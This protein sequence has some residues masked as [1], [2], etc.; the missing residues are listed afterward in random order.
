M[1]KEKFETSKREGV[2]K[3]FAIL[4]VIGKVSTR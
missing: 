2:H 4:R 1:S 3:E